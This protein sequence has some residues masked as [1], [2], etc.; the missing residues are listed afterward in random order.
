MG[1]PTLVGKV[2]DKIWST[3]NWAVYDG[4]VPVIRTF[5]SSPGWR[6]TSWWRSRSAWSMKKNSTNVTIWKHKIRIP[7]QRSAVG[8]SDV[9]V[10]GRREGLGYS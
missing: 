2:V 4:E 5:R 10:G 9:E 1:L 3:M 7:Q 8:Y 6:T